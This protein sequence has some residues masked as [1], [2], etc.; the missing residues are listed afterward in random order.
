MQ[1]LLIKFGPQAMVLAV[2]LYWSWPAL[3]TAF[4]QVANTAQHADVKKPMAQDFAATVLSP[5]FLPFPKRNPFLSADYKPNKKAA[6]AQ[7]RK[8]GAKRDG[9]STAADTRDVNLVLNATCIMGKQRMAIINGHVYKEK[10]V[11]PQPGDEA[12]SCFVTAILPHKV[13][14]S[15]RGEIMQLGYVNLAAKPAPANSPLKPA[16]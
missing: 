1:T 10:D 6:M 3:E 15:C 7:S 14:L 13:V 12:P 5:K 2:A 16:K 8:P 9:A 4:P 11:I